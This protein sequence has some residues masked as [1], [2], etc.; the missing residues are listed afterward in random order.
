MG[1]MPTVLRGHVF[2]FHIEQDRIKFASVVERRWRA[3]GTSQ[4]EKT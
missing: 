1:A 4:E 3:Y 2:L